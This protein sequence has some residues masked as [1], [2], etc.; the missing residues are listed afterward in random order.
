MPEPR[1]SPTLRRR[2]LSSEL[3]A[4]RQAAGLTSV[5][6]TK[7][8]GWSGGR[9]TRMERGEWVRPNPRDIQ[10]L[11]DLYGVTDERQRDYL[12]TLAREGR[13]KGWWQ[14]YSKMLS[15]T[16][17]TYI[18]LESGAS[19]LYT[20]DQVVFPG[21]LQCEGYARAIVADGPAEVAAADVEQRV[22]VR[23]ERQQ[24]LTRE[25]EPLRLWVVVDEAAL[26]RQVGGPDVLRDQLAHVLR[27]SEL[28]KVTIQIIPFAKGAYAA[29]SGAF[30]I[31]RFP[32]P[33]DPAAVYVETPAGELFVEDGEEVRRFEV[34]YERL[35]AVA[36]SPGDSLTLIAA[37]AAKT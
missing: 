32:E 25:Q 11:C 10:D 1:R 37:T 21:L 31:L 22:K 16:Y 3:L 23:M 15:E 13:E 29:T 17:S 20:C 6:A 36:L 7:R 8:L 30:T 5:E 27:M 12:V 2:R 34:A 24:L 19:E 28:A 9:L 14:G 18:G 35:Q 4:L 26:H 33:E